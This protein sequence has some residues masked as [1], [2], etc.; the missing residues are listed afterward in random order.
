MRK[1]AIIVAT[2]ALV[3]GSAGAADAWGKHRRHID[4]FDGE[5]QPGYTIVETGNADGWEATLIDPD[6]GNF[7]DSP[8]DN[9]AEGIKLRV[10]DKEWDST[11]SVRNTFA[12]AVNVTDVGPLS[13]DFQTIISGSPELRVTFGNGDFIRESVSDCYRELVP[14]HEGDTSWSRLSLKGM[15]CD[16]TVEGS[17]FETYANWSAFVNANPNRNIKKVEVR[18]FGPLQGLRIVDNLHLG[19]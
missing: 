17:V 6:T 8:A 15:G 5:L 18:A 4:A 16:F 9:D 12:T 7:A 19:D 13:F 1:I 11:V 10:N 2:A 14:T 3:L